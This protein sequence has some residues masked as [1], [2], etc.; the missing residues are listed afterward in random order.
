MVIYQRIKLPYKLESLEPIISSQTMYYHYEVLHKNYE[1]KLNETL[2]GTE[3][4]KGYLSLEE[5]MKNVKKLPLEIQ[6]DVCFFGGG[7][8]NHNFF[9]AHLTKIDEK[10]ENNISPSLLSLIRE[11]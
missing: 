9:F 6:A 11:N 2:K 5:L 7:L 8:T 4:E 3:I 1:V 10:N